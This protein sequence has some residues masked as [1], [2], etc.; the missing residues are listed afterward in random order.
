MSG[1]GLQANVR[2][3]PVGDLP[4]VRYLGHMYGPKPLGYWTASRSQA[5]FKYLTPGARYEVTQ[6]FTDYDA[7]LHQVGETWAFLGHTFLPHD[8]GL[9]WFVSLDGQSEWHIRLQWR[10]DEQGRLIDSLADY[11]RTVS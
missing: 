1:S 10:D 6:D 11:I 7:K 9:S 3:R 2:Y 4:N 8:D 5:A